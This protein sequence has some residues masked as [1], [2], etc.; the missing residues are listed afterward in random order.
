MAVDLG[1]LL[2]TSDDDVV[3][4]FGISPLCQVG[5]DPILVVDIQVTTLRSP[6]ES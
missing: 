1:T 3:D 5:H 4:V 6:E 2:L